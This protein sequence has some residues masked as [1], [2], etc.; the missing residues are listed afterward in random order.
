MNTLIEL[1]IQ[2]DELE[3]ISEGMSNSFV[4]GL[5]EGIVL[6]KAIYIYN[7]D[8][9]YKSMKLITAIN[10]NHQKEGYAV[11][12]VQDVPATFEAYLGLTE[13]DQSIFRKAIVHFHTKGQTAS[14]NTLVEIAEKLVKS[15]NISATDQQ[16][17]MEYWE[18]WED[19]V[20]SEDNN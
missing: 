20:D 4:V 12:S 7:N 16:W 18:D 15:A 13:L 2:K 19:W 1:G 3:A 9:R 10:T 8:L 11:I 5:K 17:Y 14:T 6:G